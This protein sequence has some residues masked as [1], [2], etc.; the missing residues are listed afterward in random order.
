MGTCPT[1]AV[2]NK[3][4]KSKDTYIINESDFDETKHKKVMVKKAVE[5]EEVSEGTDSVD[6]DASL[7]KKGGK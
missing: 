3:E 7:K 6:E 2:Q 5:P 4:G 1:V